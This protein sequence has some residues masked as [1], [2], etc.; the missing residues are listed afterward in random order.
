MLPNSKSRQQ[1]RKTFATICY[2]PD[3]KVKE[4][5]SYDMPIA[6][7]SNNASFDN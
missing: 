7:E 4:Q 6:K 2:D 5:E 3:L 1:Y